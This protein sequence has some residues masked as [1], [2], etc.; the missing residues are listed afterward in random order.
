MSDADSCCIGVQQLEQS[1][2]VDREGWFEL[3]DQLVGDAVAECVGRLNGGRHEEGPW[4]VRRLS[5]SQLLQPGAGARVE[6]HLQRGA[7]QLARL[8]TEQ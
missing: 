8:A 4:Q 6:Q 1:L 5:V 2:G 7:E 3:D